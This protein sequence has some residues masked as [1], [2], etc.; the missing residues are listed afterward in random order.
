MFY[1]A[2]TGI[3]CGCILLVYG[4]LASIPANM[5]ETFS[6]CS[7]A[8]IAALIATRGWLMSEEQVMKI[9]SNCYTTFIC[10]LIALVLA[11]S[12]VSKIC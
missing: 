6:N 1:L 12:F 3:L 9:I 11:L 7:Y 2:I 4:L 5:I 10:F 8:I